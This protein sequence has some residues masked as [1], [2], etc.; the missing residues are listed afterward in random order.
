[1]IHTCTGVAFLFDPPATSYNYTE[2]SNYRA[3]PQVPEVVEWL[4]SVVHRL[5]PVIALLVGCD[6]PLHMYSQRRC[7][8]EHLACSAREELRKAKLDFSK[9]LLYLVLGLSRG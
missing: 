8:L 9:L 6:Q 2:G 7:S 4:P 3:L 5:P 1:M